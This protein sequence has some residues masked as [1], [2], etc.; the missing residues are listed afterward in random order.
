MTSRTHD[1]IAFTSLTTIAALNPPESIN[2]MTLVGGFVAADV[3]SLL[4]DMDQ[5]G[6]D[7]WDILPA[8][9]FLGK[10]FRRIFYKHRTLTHSFLGVF[11]IYTFFSWLLFKI[12]DP[13]FLDPGIL[14]TSL[15]IGYVSHLLADCF[16]KEGLP[17]LFPFKWS[18][19]I[20][21]FERLRI[22]TGGKLEKYVLYPG[23]WLFLFWFIYLHQEN[24]RRL[25]A[26]VK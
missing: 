4:P 14:L 5:A 22:K 15:M 9:E 25:F 8:G 2:L 11:L 21:P 16:T 12:F 23:I 18:F 19:G 17:L 26:L 1:A 20:P 7:L 6:N 10:V 3:G 13:S 24:L